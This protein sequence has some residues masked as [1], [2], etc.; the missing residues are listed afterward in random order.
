MKKTRRPGRATDCEA[1]ESKQR[2]LRQKES[3]V[4]FFLFSIKMREGLRKVT[5]RKKDKAG[6]ENEFY[7]R[8]REE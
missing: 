2:E 5:M 3:F 7:G 4:W 6:I 1:R 8:K